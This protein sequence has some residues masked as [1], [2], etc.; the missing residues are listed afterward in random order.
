MRN[1][2]PLLRFNLKTIPWFVWMLSFV[3][4]GMAIIFSRTT[5]EL[6]GFE[7]ELG[8]FPLFYSAMIGLFFFSEAKD[9]RSTST[10]WLTPVPHGEFLLTRPIPRES[11]WLMR[12]SLFFMCVLAGP[13]LNLCLTQFHPDMHLSL[14]QSAT[15]HTEAAEKLALYRSVFPA[16]I[17]IHAPGASHDTLIVPGGY[18]LVA[19]WQLFRSVIV[20]LG[21]QILP[22]LLIPRKAKDK[23]LFGW[24]LLIVF[25]PEWK[26]IGVESVFFQFAR[27]WGLVTL[28]AIAVIC[29]IQ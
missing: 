26:A 18:L 4:I 12:S 17:V 5:G 2:S 1:F 19:G 16:S 8:G 20:A 10:A 11:A 28:G 27:H 7:T 15:Q 13:V 6:S 22:L 14:Y 9:G 24:M 3:T 21:L 29:L 25:L 23:I